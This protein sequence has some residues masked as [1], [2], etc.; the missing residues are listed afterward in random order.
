MLSYLAV[1]IAI[2]AS[3]SVIIHQIISRN[4]Y[5]QFENNALKGAKKA[6][7]I[8]DFI[9]HEHEEYFNSEDLNLTLQDLIHQSED[10]TNFTQK[11]INIYKKNPYFFANEDIAIQW[12]NEKKQ[13]LV[14]EGDLKLNIKEFADD[15]ITK[16][17]DEKNHL[18]SLILPIRNNQNN[19]IIGYIKV[20]ESTSLLN[21][22]LFWLKISLILGGGF[23]LILTTGGAFFLTKQ[24]LQPIVASFQE[25]K[26]FTADASHELRTPLTVI[27]TSAELVLN[28]QGKISEDNLH[29]IQTIVS[30]TEEMRILVNDL[31]LLARMDKETTEKEKLF[32]KLPLDEICEDLL[33]LL[34]IE[35]ESRQISLKSYITP[36]I[37]VMG[38]ASHLQRLLTNIL[39]NAL[40][41]T[42]Q[43]GKVTFS[44]KQ[45]LNWII[46]T[47]QDTGI[48]I[49]PQELNNIFQRFWRGEEGRI[50]RKEGS[51]LGLAIAEKIAIH[52]GGKITVESILSQGST[53]KIYLPSID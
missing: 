30:A 28:N 16:Y 14:R 20:I 45:E 29:K 11:N 34:Y 25:L 9:K 19:Q 2:L 5:R 6:G 41:Y 40:Q 1:M 27:K 21:N 4:L 49:N 32:I 15:K 17:Y 48:G 35:A 42:P 10:N 36:N 18:F 13:V 24:S 50:K 23:A 31:L 39:T 12:L 43:G 46:I 52:H 38:N 53:F 51:G 44:L 3:T 8:L 33:D 37:W 47:I 7:L 22:N 26:Q